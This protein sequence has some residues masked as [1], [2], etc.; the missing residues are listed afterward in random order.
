MAGLCISSVRAA[1][2][3]HANVTNTD[4]MKRISNDSPVALASLRGCAAP[5]LDLGPAADP[6]GFFT[7]GSTQA[8]ARLRD[9]CGPGMI[10]PFS[11]RHSAP[12]EG[13]IGHER[14]KEGVS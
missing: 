9:K 3:R 13:L 4:S 14:H 8:G 1:G 11:G 12:V 2:I 7:E 6:P 10:L 5:S